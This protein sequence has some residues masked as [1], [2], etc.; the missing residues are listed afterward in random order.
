M[1]EIFKKQIQQ[2]KE[3]FN[4]APAIYKKVQTLYLNGSCQLLTRSAQAFELLVNDEDT[5]I[6]VKITVDDNE[7]VNYFQ[8]NKLCEW[9]SYAF[10]SLLQMIE[11]FNKPLAKTPQ[12]GKSYTREGMIKRVL[13]ERI[14]KADKAK[15]NLIYADNIYGEH[16][17]INEKGH[18]YKVTLRNFDD[19]TGYINNPDL[20]TNKLGTTKHLIY[21]FKK[22]K[23]DTIQFKKLSKTYPFVEIFLDPQNDYRITWHYPHPLKPEIELLL[24]KYFGSKNYIEPEK[25][26]DFTAFIREAVDFKQ[27]TIRPEVEEKIQKAWDE[28]M[29]KN[30]TTNEKIDFSIIKADLFPYQKEGVRFATFKSGAILADE[31][32]L[33]KTIQAITTAVQK[34]KIFGFKKTLIVCPASLKEQ[35]KQEIEKFC[36]ETAVIADGMPQARAE[37]YQKSK[38]YFVIVNYE[39]VMR[40]CLVINRMGADFIILDEAQKIKNFNTLAAQ[41]IKKLQKKH[42]LVITGT[43]IENR[44][45][46]LYSIVQFIEP[47][48]LSP[49]WEFSYQHC[50]FDE[51]KTD[52]ITGYYNLQ[53][54]NERLQPILLRREKHN[55]IKDLP[56]IT[57]ITIPVEMHLEQEI[58]H[59]NFA[60]GVAS[61]ITKKFIS[62]FD[63]QKLMLLMNNMR[64]VC[65]STFLIDKETY[66][67]PKLV[68]L[69]DML[70]EKLDIKNSGSKI[71]IFSEWVTMLNLIGKM[72][73][74]NGIGFAMLSGKV[75][76]KNR[77]AL[78]KK[79][80]ADP[81][82]SVFLSTEAGGAGLNLQVADT[83]INFEVPWNP[84][85]KN[86]RVGRIDRL[87][88]RSKH[89]NVINFITKNS[90]EIKIASGLNLKQNLFDSVLNNGNGTD[91]VDFSASGRAQFLQQLEEA[92][93]GFVTIE[94]PPIEEEVLQENTADKELITNYVLIEE[95]ETSEKNIDEI[96]QPIID[97]KIKAQQMEQVMNHGLDFL[98]GLY[99]MAT[100][101]TNGLENRKM[102]FD[103]ATGEIV[104]RF[105]LPNV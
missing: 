38:A 95:E 33:G 105:K 97:Q 49:L 104:M 61:I 70:L 90:I 71:I 79:F 54:L 69:K 35:W 58:L 57:E 84:A 20:Q 93:N 47:H 39:T 43:P 56:Q 16:T 80:E 51:S 15:Y 5:D 27:I 3:K 42:A 45:I 64:M 4:S 31:M 28:D 12:T 91:E 14:T 60:R 34:K 21:A 18:S 13:A 30:A 59:A 65:N 8:K 9:D 40:D 98:S 46:D 17:L 77:D 7:T 74:E 103:E 52:K 72:L 67:S 24:N 82:C 83:V 25:I 6:E 89:L 63:M 100:G 78:V 85:K 73:H 101:S 41:S 76:I 75:A 37:I 50:Y 66:Y 86:Q 48:F 10:A 87:G 102:E 11:E 22:L 81:N 19:E 53:Q 62:P 32:G 26:K 88:Q 92:I 55:V 99:K 29:L 94:K 96:Q 2:L 36:H 68:E 23:A 1:V 44:L